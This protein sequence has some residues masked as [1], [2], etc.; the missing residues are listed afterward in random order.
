MHE[1]LLPP[2]LPAPL[3]AKAKKGD[4]LLFF[5]LKPDGKLDAASLHTG[6]PVVKGV[7]WTG[8][9]EGSHH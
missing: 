3:A 8:A 4:A 5:S 6:C 2:T 9:P 1:W 7:K